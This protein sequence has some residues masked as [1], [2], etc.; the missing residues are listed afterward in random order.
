MKCCVTTDAYIIIEN[1]FCVIVLLKDKTQGMV[2][3]MQHHPRSVRSVRRPSQSLGPSTQRARVCLY[4]T[5]INNTV[6]VVSFPS[7][8]QLILHTAAT[9]LWN[10]SYVTEMAPGQ[11]ATRVKLVSRTL[12]NPAPYYARVKILPFL[13]I[14][15]A[16]AL[17]GYQA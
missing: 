5:L 1:I 10:H 11:N 6:D 4:V 7:F 3:Y 17:A 16:L 2:W 14:S 9:V 13:P 8:V 15:A 12:Q